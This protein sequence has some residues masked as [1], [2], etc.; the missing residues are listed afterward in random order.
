MLKLLV[1]L[2]GSCGLLW[3]AWRFATW[4]LLVQL[5]VLAALFLW[6][7]GG[8]VTLAYRGRQIARHAREAAA[9]QAAEPHV[10]PRIAYIKLYGEDK[11]L[12]IERIDPMIWERIGAVRRAAK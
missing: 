2:A 12:A 7:V 9:D 1:W 11:A 8:G 4:H 6:V 3:L 10:H 5:L